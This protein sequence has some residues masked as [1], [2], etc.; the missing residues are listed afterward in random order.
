MLWFSIVIPALEP[1]VEVD[2]K[3]CVWPPKTFSSLPLALIFPDDVISP[4]ANEVKVPTEVI[5]ACAAV[6]K[7]PNNF[8]LALIS[9]EAVVLPL[10]INSDEKIVPLALI[11]PEDETWLLNLH[12]LLVLMF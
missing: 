6:P 8:P 4:T 12:T 7:V 2:N 11:W 9:P 10:T 1:V 5:L 3:K